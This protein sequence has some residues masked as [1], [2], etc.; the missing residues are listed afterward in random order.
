WQGCAESGL[1]YPVQR[2]TV[3]TDADGLFPAQNLSKPQKLLASTTQPQVNEKILTA[4]KDELQAIEQT[5]ITDKALTEEK[6][7]EIQVAAVSE[8]VVQPEVE[9][10]EK[11]DQLI[12]DPKNQ[13]SS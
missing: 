12:A 9:L 13:T 3:T 2:T 6:I 5:P 4:Q 10:T 7:E 11:N 1:C 8:P